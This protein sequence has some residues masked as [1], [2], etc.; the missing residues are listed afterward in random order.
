M[1]IK[2]KHIKSFREQK[3]LTQKELA[4]KTNLNTRTIQRL[5]NEE[6]NARAFTLNRIAEVLNI[7]VNSFD[8]QK[9]KKAIW[10][11]VI[12]VLGLILLNLGIIFVFGYLVMDAQ[13][14]FNSFIGAL[15][16]S[17]FMPFTIYFFTKS[18]SKEERLLKYSSGLWL[19]ILVF[20][21]LHGPVIVISKG[22][23]YVVVFFSTSLYLFPKF[24]VVKNI[25]S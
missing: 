24:K 21:L 14:N 6:T 3:G 23:F 10:P 8:E 1:K 25:T 19:Y 5:E 7:P 22:L 4:E 20:M 15:L 13:A 18:I 11:K 12:N 2:G 9:T 16:L 17:V